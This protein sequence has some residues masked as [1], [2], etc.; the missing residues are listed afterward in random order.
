MKQN[1]INTVSNKPAAD[2]M[3]GLQKS[4]LS[5]M[6]DNN[7]IALAEREVEHQVSEANK[8]NDE[9]LLYGPRTVGGVIAVDEDGFELRLAYIARSPDNRRETEF[10]WSKSGVTS[11]EWVLDDK[12]YTQ[13]E[14]REWAREMADDEGVPKEMSP[15]SWMM[16]TAK[17]PNKKLGDLLSSQ[18]SLQSNETIPTVFTSDQA[19]EVRCWLQ[20][21]VETG[22]FDYYRYNVFSKR[23][24]AAEE[25]VDHIEWA[26]GLYAEMVAEEQREGL[27][28]E[29]NEG[30]RAAAN[31]KSDEE[32]ARI[33]AEMKAGRC[34]NRNMQAWLDTLENPAKDAYHENGVFNLS[35][36]AAFIG[37]R[38]SE[39]QK[40][41]KQHG[42]SKYDYAALAR[43]LCEYVD[44]NLSVRVKR[45]LDQLDFA[46]KETYANDDFWKV[47]LDSTASA[48]PFDGGCLICA[49]AIV[50]A[51][52]RGEIVRIV[53]DLNDGQTEH[54]GVR[55]CSEIFD[56]GG[57]HE[58]PDAWIKWLAEEEGITDRTLSFAEGMGTELCILS[59][60]TAENAIA[61][62]IRD[63][64]PEAVHKDRLPE[65]I[66]M[67]GPR[68]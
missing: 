15:Y 53:S 12:W 25:G 64:R 36:Y 28:V 9:T 58:S 52:G 56:F 5:V 11:A 39:F 14:V 19:K 62:M 18:S 17:I 13:D 47:I 41:Q 4:S 33:K 61:V 24:Q 51:A 29:E 55:I 31:Q 21:Y 57:R 50:A 8:A 60:C 67:G 68:G 26:T 49:K 48:G 3:D 66:T 32:N 34:E 37:A 38:S 59:D 6:S 42:G 54:Y 1:P 7:A 30:A 10:T 46:I 23:L 40:I 65:K 43:H 2:K 44:A 27:R 16:A 22:H 45:E 20:K 35:S 63:V